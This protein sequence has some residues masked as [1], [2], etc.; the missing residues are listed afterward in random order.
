MGMEPRQAGPRVP[1]LGG[2]DN[3][4][5]TP[6]KL[7]ATLRPDRALD[8][9]QDPGLA[10]PPE[11]ASAQRALS[12]RSARAM[13]VAT[14]ADLRD[15]FRLKP[16]EA[17]HAIADLT[18]AGVLM[19]VKIRGWS[20]KA[21]LHRDARAPRRVRGA[22][23]LAPFD[24]LV[25]ERGRIERLF[26]LRYRIEIYVPQHRRTHGY[27]VLPFLLDGAL[28]ARV[29]L[30]ADRQAGVLRAQRLT[31]ERGAPVDTIARLRDEL[32]AMATWLRRPEVVLAT[33]IQPD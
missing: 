2:P 8:P 7:R 23:L 14:A 26:G 28:V 1:V 15:Y 10:H 5:D 17:G 9:S 24:P 33:I 13:G 3:Q 32:S 22:A 21:W 16:A 11:A 27:Y 20:M 4:R 31:L 19:P 6:P 25:W 12:D 18:E 29:D 30:E